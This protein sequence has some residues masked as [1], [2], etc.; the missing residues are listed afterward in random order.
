M[1]E[2]RGTPHSGGAHPAGL[3]R[4]K[5]SL[6][7]GHGEA[8][9]GP[10]GCPLLPPAAPRPV[11]AIS[12]AA[13][14]QVAR[15]LPWFSSARS[16]SRRQLPAQVPS[17]PPQTPHPGS[18]APGPPALPGL[19]T[20]GGRAAAAAAEEEKEGGRGGRTRARTRGWIFPPP[21][22]LPPPSRP[23]LG[24][25]FPLPPPRRVRLPPG[26]PPAPLRRYRPVMPRGLSPPPPALPCAPPGSPSGSGV[27]PDPTHPRS[28]PGAPQLP[29]CGSTAGGAAA[30]KVPAEPRAGLGSRGWAGVTG[31]GSPPFHSHSPQC[32]PPHWA[33]CW[34]EGEQWHRSPPPTY[35]PR[36]SQSAGGL[37]AKPSARW[38]AGAGWGEAAARSPAHRVTPMP[39][40]A[41]LQL[42]RG[43]T[44]TPAFSAQSSGTGTACC[45]PV[46]HQPP[47][48]H[49]SPA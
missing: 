17:R 12:P 6:E 45:G 28:C 30:G 38:K 31:T 34:A 26:A 40:G 24:G 2:A 49:P 42:V 32:S 25:R 37:L 14:P 18:A 3:H 29:R 15:L 36:G 5:S 7:V 13:R 27:P 8:S 35:L 11:P 44:Q 23:C 1:E 22:P 9:V 46:C 19:A 21:A 41:S 10:P 16:P 33:G 47:R 39:T 48:R 20:A 4:E 43:L